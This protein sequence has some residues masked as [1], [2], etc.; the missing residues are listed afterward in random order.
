ML[1]K[2]RACADGYQKLLKHL[3]GVSF[4][5]DAPINILTILESNG[6]GDALWCLRATSQDC[7]VVARLIAADFAESV[8]HIFE[9]ENSSD[10]RPRKTVEAV[11]AFAL[12]EVSSDEMAAS[13]AATRCAASWAASLD[14]VMA[15]SLDGSLDVVL[16]AVWDVSWD[17]ARTAALDAIWAAS[18]DAAWGASLEVSLHAVRTAAST[19]NL[20]AVRSAASSAAWDAAWGAQA[21]IMRKYLA[22]GKFHAQH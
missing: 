10:D 5:H 14:A 18:L 20:H 16:D 19:A 6:V 2:A 4:D 13:W 11:R 21:E 15:A 8:L 22:S 1:K 17:A 9:K 7:S 3:G 12:G